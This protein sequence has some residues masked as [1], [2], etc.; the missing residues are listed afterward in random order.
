MLYNVYHPEIDG[1][2]EININY[3]SQINVL[4]KLGFSAGKAVPVN[5][6]NCDSFEKCGYISIHG[7]CQGKTC[8]FIK[9]G[10]DT[11]MI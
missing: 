10:K 2:I 6:L 11:G 3:L 4:K 9:K 5:F 7:K 8:S 1:S